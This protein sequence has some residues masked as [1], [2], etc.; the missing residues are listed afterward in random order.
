M[1]INKIENEVIQFKVLDKKGIC[2]RDQ[3]LS[4]SVEKFLQDKLIQIQ[5]IKKYFSPL[6]ILALCQNKRLEPANKGAE[7]YLKEA[8]KM[9]SDKIKKVEEDSMI[10]Q[11]KK[12]IIT[13][14]Q[15][16]KKIEELSLTG[17]NKKLN[18]KNAK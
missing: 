4:R 18:I 2:Y 12:K 17:D 9:Q 6:S 1:D 15:I 11:E 14:G 16:N 8:K 5:D 3:K 10:K 7:E 13:L